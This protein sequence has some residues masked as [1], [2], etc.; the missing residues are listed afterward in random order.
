M[1]EEMPVAR[2]HSREARAKYW[3]ALAQR[4]PRVPAEW[5]VTPGKATGP[6]M[7]H[8]TSILS[9]IFSPDG[10]QILAA[11]GGRIPGC[12]S[13]IRIWD[14]ASGK[15]LKI[16]NGHVCGIYQLAL[17][18]RTGILASASEDYSVFLWDLEQPDAIFL[19]GGDPVVKG[20]IAFAAQASLLAI[21]ETEAYED[22]T[23]ATFVIDLDTGEEVFRHQLKRGD[24][25]SSLAISST[26]GKLFFT[27]QD[28]HHGND[29]DAFC[30]DLATGKREWKRSFREVTF[31]DLVLLAGEERLAAAVMNH[32][33]RDT[34]SGAYLLDTKSGRLLARRLL[35]GIGASV[36][37]SSTGDVLA[38]AHGEGVVELLGPQNLS[39]I[40]ALADP[41]SKGSGFCSVQISPDGKTV[42]AG[43]AH[44]RLTKFD[45]AT[46][47][48][49]APASFESPAPSVKAADV[50]TELLGLLPDGCGS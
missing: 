29:T 2:S 33:E 43:D 46:P 34:L 14:A 15:E 49:A 42:I 17:D 21:G 35:P 5:S 9:C 18:P 37:A 38:V 12:D 44:G 25:T 6:E 1:W 40:K 39:P 41:S 47:G 7:K 36:A 26:G 28:F 4:F 8:G 48:F 50:G 23:S 3:K 19:A 24:A 22:L 31:S 11:G 45:A 32:E 16:G 10:K 27:V 13:S 30:W 20:H